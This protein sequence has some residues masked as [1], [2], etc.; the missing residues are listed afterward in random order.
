MVREDLPC[1][2]KEFL[3]NWREALAMPKECGKFGNVCG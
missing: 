3:N 2:H 1:N